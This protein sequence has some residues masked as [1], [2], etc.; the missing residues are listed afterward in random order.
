VEKKATEVYISWMDV[1]RC[2]LARWFTLR[3]TY[4]ISQGIE[5]EELGE[6]VAKILVA[7]CRTGMRVDEAINNL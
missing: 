5:G 6:Q 3:K 2:Q 1:E 7:G 4:L